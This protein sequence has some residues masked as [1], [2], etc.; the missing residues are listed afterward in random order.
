M[1]S[2]AFMQ[3][4]LELLNQD[5]RIYFD[6]ENMP[7]PHFKENS[8]IAA[9]FPEDNIVFV[10]AKATTNPLD[11]YILISINLYDLKQAKENVSL[12]ERSLY[13]RAFAQYIIQTV[14]EIN[15]EDNQTDEFRQAVSSLSLQY[16]KEKIHE[17][18]VQFYEDIE[19][20]GEMLSYND[21][22]DEFDIKKVS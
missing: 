5:C 4:I 21:E 1:I 19:R 20:I 22:D 7:Y 15:I 14:M 9:I 8:S 16:P 17:V 13:S 11:F 6:K 3:G 12:L 2:L 18:M 10:D